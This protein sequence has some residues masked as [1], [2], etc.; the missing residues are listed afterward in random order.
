MKSVLVIRRCDLLLNEHHQRFCVHFFL[1][2]R[3]CD[4]LLNEHH[5]RF[6]VHFCL[7]TEANAL[8]YIELQMQTGL[9]QVEN[10][11]DGSRISDQ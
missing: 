9:L 5:Q 10:M 1:V 11:F 3:W 7:T 2:I 4:L 8:K 6:C